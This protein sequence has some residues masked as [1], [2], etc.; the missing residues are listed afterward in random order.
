MDQFEEMRAEA[1]AWMQ[2]PIMPLSDQI[3]RLI[4]N[5]IQYIKLRM[6]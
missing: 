2:E 4:R 1:E 3:K 5:C 6:S